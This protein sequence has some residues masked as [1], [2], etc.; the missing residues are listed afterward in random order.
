MFVILVNDNI[1]IDLFISNTVNTVNELKISNIFEPGQFVNSA[2][3]VLLI[4]Y[5]Q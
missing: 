5:I 1:H 3:V 4:G 2:E